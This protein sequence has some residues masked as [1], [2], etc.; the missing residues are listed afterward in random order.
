MR[1]PTKYSRL[2]EGYPP[3]QNNGHSSRNESQDRVH[4]QRMEAAKHSIRSQ[5]EETIKHT[6]EDVLSY[7]DKTTQ[8]L[9]NEQTDEPCIGSLLMVFGVPPPEAGPAD[10]N[11]WYSFIRVYLLVWWGRSCDPFS[12]PSPP[13]VFSC[14]TSILGSVSLPVGFRRKWTLGPH[15]KIQFG[16]TSF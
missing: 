12:L 10:H 9:R 3:S 4:Q 1:D 13:V 6:V 8:D 11:P 2:L 14:D 7:V 5:I 16:L 15:T